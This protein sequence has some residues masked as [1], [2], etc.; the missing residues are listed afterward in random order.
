V[1]RSP[2]PS[3]DSGHLRRV[4]DVSQPHERGVIDSARFDA[5][6]KMKLAA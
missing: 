1:S 2:D 6:I 5:K 3:Y 4:V